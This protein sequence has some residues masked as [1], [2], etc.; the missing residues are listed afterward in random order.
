VI[1]LPPARRA[2][3]GLTLI[4]LLVAMTVGLLVMLAAGAALTSA[5]RGFI[6][7]DAASQL[8]DSGRFAADMIQRIGVQTGYRDVFFAATLRQSSPTDPAPNITGF[9]DAKVDPANPLTSS[10]VGSAS[11]AGAGSDVL[12]LRYQPAQLHTMSTDAALKTVADQTMIDC[13][14]N[15][16]SAVL[17]LDDASARDA[18]M[19]S[20]FSV[21]IS[22]GEPSLLCTYLDPKTLT[23]MTSPIVQGIENFQVL[24]GVDGVVANTVPATPVTALNVPNVPNGYL[25]AD[26]MT[27]VGN[28]AAT[29]ANWRRVRS[30]RIGMVLRGAR[31]TT[32]DMQPQPFY[33]LGSTANG[34]SGATGSAFASSGDPGT[35]FIPTPDGRLRQVVTFT[36][37]LR[38]DQGL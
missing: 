15:A 33:P 4:E 26:Q 24:Y 1:F 29:N 25:R 37:H 27:V 9:N 35:T 17:D 2:A 38:N 20:V 23:W 12:I 31:G 6:T 11:E 16:P 34:S 30:L 13:A 7:V 21:G 3:S 18:R 14:G 32:Q 10:T 5:Q 19:A 36:I 28:S 22:Q 8:R